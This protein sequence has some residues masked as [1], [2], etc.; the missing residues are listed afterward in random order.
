MP[1]YVEITH[2]EDFSSAHRLFSPDLDEEQNKA[3]YGPCY[4]LHG[5]NYGLEITVRGPL[6]PDTGMVMDLNILMQAMKRELIDV[7]DHVYLNEDVD[8]LQGIIP[9]SE[10]LAVAFWERMAPHVPDSI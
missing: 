7:V 10:N 9:T 3:L 4:V 6:D 2:R 1:N 5:H 8:F